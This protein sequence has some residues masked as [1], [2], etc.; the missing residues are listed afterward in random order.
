VGVK[1]WCASVS[2]SWL[3]E[4]ARTSASGGRNSRVV[5]HRCTT[6]RTT[7]RSRGFWQGFWGEG[8]RYLV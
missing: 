1:Q 4:M 8:R 6:C 2:D 7:V 5:D 3:V